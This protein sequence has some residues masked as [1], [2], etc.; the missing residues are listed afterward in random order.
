MDQ[1][2]RS[3]HR[4]PFDGRGLLSVGHAKRIHCLVRDVSINGALV[5]LQDEIHA[6]SGMVGELGLILRGRVRDNEVTLEFGIEV[7]WQ[8]GSL[9]GC[10]FIRVDPHSFD[11]L[12]TF[13]SDNLGDPALL[14]R[15]LTKLGY[16]PGVG[17]EAV[18]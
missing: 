9:M 5:E 11:L 18:G 7:A 8:T 4:F 3:F 15:E 17:P 10:R 16:W 12:R 1:E 14:D 13:I 6:D 2:Q